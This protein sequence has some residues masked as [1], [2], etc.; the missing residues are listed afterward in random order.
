MID[1]LAELHNI[2]L[3]IFSF[4][5][6]Y[7]FSRI[8]I[9]AA[10]WITSQN[11]NVSNLTH[12]SKIIFWYAFQHRN[13]S[14][15]SPQKSTKIDKIPHLFIIQ[16][17]TYGEY[18]SS[19]GNLRWNVYIIRKIGSK[20]LLFRQWRTRKNEA[21]VRLNFLNQ[22]I[23]PV[24]IHVHTWSVPAYTFNGSLFLNEYSQ[25]PPGDDSI[26]HTKRNI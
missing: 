2:L 20:C 16:H 12:I 6:F 26:A 18:A 19:G 17:S 23:Q 3:Y 11:S 5:L 14:Y 13:I 8:T 21:K 24:Y 15:S 10:L 9:L 1:R 25:E 4:A 22:P 7:H